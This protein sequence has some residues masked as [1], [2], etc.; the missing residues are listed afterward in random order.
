[1]GGIPC[2]AILGSI[3]D[4]LGFIFWSCWSPMG[5]QDVDICSPE[6]ANTEEIDTQ[7]LAVLPSAPKFKRASRSLPRQV[8][9]VSIPFDT[10][11]KIQKINFLVLETLLDPL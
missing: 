2:N 10:V 6:L 1:M 4:P 8:L 3:W 7:V 9:K 11:V 5:M